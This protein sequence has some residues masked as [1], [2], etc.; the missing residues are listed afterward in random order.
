MR[1]YI[2]VQISAWTR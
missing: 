2:I 1:S